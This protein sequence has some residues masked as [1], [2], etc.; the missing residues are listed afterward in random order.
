M[1]GQME[2]DVWELMEWVEEAAQLGLNRH[3]SLLHPS[4]HTSLLHPSLLHPALY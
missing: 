1:F 4:L 3:S 2:N